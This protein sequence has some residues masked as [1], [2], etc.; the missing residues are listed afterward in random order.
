M[1]IPALEGAHGDL[2]GRSYTMAT[3]LEYLT[4]PI[5]RRQSSVFTRALT[6]VIVALASRQ[7]RENPCSERL[8]A[9]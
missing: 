2:R 4:S 9:G 7:R 5:C 6:R 3:S 1:V 8:P